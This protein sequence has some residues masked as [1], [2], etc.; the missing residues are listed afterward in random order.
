MG[1]GVTSFSIN[2]S[3]VPAALVSI[4]RMLRTPPL[5]GLESADQLARQAAVYAKIWNKKAAKFFEVTVPSNGARQAQQD[6]CLKLS[7]NCPADSLSSSNTAAE[8]A[9]DDATVVFDAASL[10]SRRHPVPVL[11]SDY[12]FELLFNQPSEDRLK[13]IAALVAAPF[14]AGLVTDAGMVVANPVY[15]NAK[16]KNLFNHGS[17]HGIVVW[18][19]QQALMAA[20]FARQLELKRA[21]PLQPET[22]AALRAAQTKLWAVI[23]KHWDLRRSELCGWRAENGRA[24]PVSFSELTKDNTEPNAIQL[25]ST[26]YLAV[27]PPAADSK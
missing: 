21:A 22:A 24:V 25:W 17:Y 4:E 8:A 16:T 6:Y 27:K 19:W 18:S 20:G 23:K 1:G 9:A 15:A 13:R 10:D 11:H 14:P 26:V 7:L 5:S 12:G 2:V 3:L